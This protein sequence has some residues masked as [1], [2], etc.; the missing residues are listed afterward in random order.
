[1]LDGGRLSFVQLGDLNHECAFEELFNYGQHQ[2][3]DVISTNFLILSPNFIR[4]IG[5]VV[6]QKKQINTFIT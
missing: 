1:M 2:N 3:L 6:N 5:T 4:L